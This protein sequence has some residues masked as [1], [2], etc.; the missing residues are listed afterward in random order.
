MRECMSCFMI[1]EI[2]QNFEL[3]ISVLVKLELD[4]PSPGV[5][6]EAWLDCTIPHTPRNATSLPS[7]NSGRLLEDQQ[8]PR[9][10]GPWHGQE[11]ARSTRPFK[12]S[13]E[14]RNQ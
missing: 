7:I 5:F 4:F 11:R 3:V 6:K 13:V 14:K 10:L 1:T 2:V 12:E 8:R 9:A